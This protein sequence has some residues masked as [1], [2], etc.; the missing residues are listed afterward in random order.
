MREPS[1]PVAVP[2]PRGHLPEFDALRGL[3]I[4]FVLYL[5]AYFSPWEVTPHRDKL[6]MHSLHLV[7]HTA[8][9][10]FLFISGFLMA[11]DHSPS[12]GDFLRRKGLRLGVPLIAWMTAALVYRAVDQGGFDWPLLKSFLLFDISGQF[13]YLFVLGVFLVLLY[14]LRSASRRTLGWVTAAAFA[15]NLATIAYYQESA[16]QGDF[17]TLAYRNPLTWVFF[18]MF[19]LYAARAWGDTRFRG[20]ALLAVLAGMAA[21]FA[22]YLVQGERL[23]GYPVSYFGVTVFLF[24]ALA[25]VAIPG[26]ASRVSSSRVNPTLQPLAALGRYS[27]A[28]YL[29]HMPFFIGFVTERFV[30]DSDAKDDFT[31][32]MNA[33]FLIGFITAL[34]FVVAV[35]VLFPRVGQLLLGI[36][37]RRVRADPLAQPD[38]APA[39]LPHGHRP[40]AY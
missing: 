25:V 28:I 39:P 32:L 29:V 18:P 4:I 12:F 34:A 33:I 24:S 17:A 13:Y 6:V 35:D 15:V 11:R 16:I 14:P 19:G 22:V 1:A 5:H 21:L 23:G 31:L 7:A 3:A 27:F 37:P 9:P 10:L 30:S 38:A 2:N 8:V 36:E 40:R 20:P 26:I